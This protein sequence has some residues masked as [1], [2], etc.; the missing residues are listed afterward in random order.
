MAIV[1]SAARTA[2][3]GGPNA[4][5]AIAAAPP[6]A[7][8]A[9]SVVVSANASGKLVFALVRDPTDTEGYLEFVTNALTPNTLPV[10]AV[11]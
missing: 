5:A 10:G 7:Y 1:A 11:P 9:F 6:A 8:G 3:S 4:N 2:V